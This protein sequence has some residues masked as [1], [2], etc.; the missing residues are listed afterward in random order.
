MTIN[1]FKQKLNRY[2]F[3]LQF[4]GFVILT[5]FAYILTRMFSLLPR[6]QRYILAVVIM[7]VCL[8]VARML[9]DKIEQCTAAILIPHER[10]ITLI[11]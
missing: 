5:P 4:G 10:A 2:I 8:S 3:V 11:F 9:R 6:E 7:S 1:S